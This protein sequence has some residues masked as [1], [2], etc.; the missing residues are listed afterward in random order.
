[1]PVY[2]NDRTCTFAGCING[3]LEIYARNLDDAPA[4]VVKTYHAMLEY[5]RAFLAATR[6]K[7]VSE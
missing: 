2:D 4:S 6:S 7:G 3:M 1:M 5:S